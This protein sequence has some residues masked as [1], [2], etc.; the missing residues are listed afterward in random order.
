MSE[1]ELEL[2]DSERDFDL[3]RQPR[4][5]ANIEIRFFGKSY[6]LIPQLSRSEKLSKNDR[7]FSMKS[8]GFYAK[9]FK[10]S[11]KSNPS[12]SIAYYS[13]ALS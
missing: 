13:K 5:M 6:E 1:L 11:R 3:I 10:S 7:A 4:I 8:S 2:I 9:W 12:I